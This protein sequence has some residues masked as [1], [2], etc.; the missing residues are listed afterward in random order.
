MD[1][2]ERILTRRPESTILFR[3]LFTRLQFVHDPVAQHPQDKVRDAYNKIIVRFARLLKTKPL[4]VRLAKSDTTLVVIKELQHKLDSIFDTL[5]L[6]DTSDWKNH[7]GEGCTEQQTK[8]KKFVSER[9]HYRLANEVDGDK[10]LKNV[11]MQLRGAIAM[12]PTGE[13]AKLRQTTLEGVLECA[14]LNGLNIYEW[15]VSREDVDYEDEAIG[16]LGTFAEARRGMWLHNGER[17][18]VVVKTLFFDTD[19]SDEDK[20]LK[21]LIFWYKLAEHDN[22]LKLYG[23]NHV[24]SPPFFVCEDAHGGNLLEFLEVMENHKHFWKVFLDVAKGIKHLH[25]RNIVHGAIK[26][27]NIL[28]GDGNVAKIADF[29]FSS[30][31]SLSLRLS[32]QGSVA[33]S[34][35]IRWTPKEVLEATESDEPQLE[36]DIYAFGMCMIEAIT[37]EIPFGMEDD[38]NVTKWVLAGNPPPRPSKA[39]DDV[40]ELI[41]GLCATNFRERPSIKNVIGMIA[42]H[43]DNNTPWQLP[44]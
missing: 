8:L 37:G 1:L 29:R 39:S 14:S 43:A 20:F 9:S 22:V 16:L 19:D 13:L 44:E 17:R 41:C 40:W 11:I 38:E 31:R 28:I 18:D 6:E 42:Q 34:R 32:E 24:S 5:E 4:L 10:K 15:F 2:D 35:S 36:S 12:D 33:Q 26:G 7:W 30:V 23:G 3:D 27:N 25:D 21:Q